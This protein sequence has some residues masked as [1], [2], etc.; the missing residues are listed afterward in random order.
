MWVQTRYGTLYVEMTDSDEAPLLMLHGLGSAGTTFHEVVPLLGSSRRAIIPDLLGFGH[1]PHSSTF[2]YTLLD[3]ARVLVDMMDRLNLERVSVIGHSMGGNVALALAQVAPQRVDQVI[4]AEANIVAT[5]GR[6]R[7][8][9]SARAD[10]ITESEY[11]HNFQQLFSD[12]RP[13][14]DDTISARHYWYTLQH[15]S[16]V[17]MYRASQALLDLKEFNVWAAYVGRVTGTLV[18]EY[19]LATL[20]VQKAI[21]S[22]V[23]IRIISHAGHDMFIDNPSECQ[24]AI[25]ALLHESYPDDPC[26][27]ETPSQQ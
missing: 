15:A 4:V 10:Q 12:L 11:V 8:S 2:S 1:S 5:R 14:D 20:Q 13:S 19:N 18:G 17:A 21:A 22:L 3:Q 16:P 26:Q 23:P 25:E 24:Q 6:H 9:I 7:H 27:S